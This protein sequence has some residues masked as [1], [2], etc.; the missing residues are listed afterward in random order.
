MF[1]ARY[2][3]ASTCSAALRPKR[4][5]RLVENKEREQRECYQTHEQDDFLAKRGSRFLVRRPSMLAERY[6]PEY[7]RAKDER[8]QDNPQP[9]VEALTKIQRQS[10]ITHRGADDYKYRTINRRW[11]SHIIKY[12]TGVM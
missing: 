7:H 8:E 10:H 6:S 11:L 12:T 1:L 2:V 5:E 4:F 9:Y 3:E